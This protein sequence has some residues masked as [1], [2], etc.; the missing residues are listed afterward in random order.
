[1]DTLP[2]I[3]MA[4][5]AGGILVWPIEKRVAQLLPAGKFFPNLRR[6]GERPELI[7]QLAP[8]LL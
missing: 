6:V 5:G 4:Q 3:L 8:G 7:L 1:M 2:V